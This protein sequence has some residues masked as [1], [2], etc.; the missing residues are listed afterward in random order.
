MSALP[1][2]LVLGGSGF[3]GQEL[4]EHFRCLATSTTPR[5]GFLQ[6]D[7]TREDDLRSKLQRAGPE[8]VVNC[9]GLADV[10]RAEREPELAEALNHRVVENLTRVRAQVPF[11]LVHISTDYVFDGERGMY[12]ESD[13]A[14]PVNEYGRSKLRGEAAALR[15]G[16]SLVVRISS[17]YGQGHGARKPQFFRYLTENM[18]S[19]KQVRAITDQRVTATYLPDLAKAIEELVHRGTSGIVHVASPEPLTR[20]EFARRVAQVARV[21][22]DLLVPSRRADMKRWV[23][24]RPANTSLDVGLSQTLG[25]RYTPV[26]ASLEQLLTR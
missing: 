20:Y 21:N 24:A 13:E 15:D 17:P 18:L 5:K 4:A 1:K 23:A 11:R 12:Q 22:P 16:E 7:A 3:V 14:R 9:V 6:I 2:L 26:N 10:D 19:G 8:V 25:V